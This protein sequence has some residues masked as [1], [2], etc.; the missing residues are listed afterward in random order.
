MCTVLQ[1]KEKLKQPAEKWQ[2]GGNQKTKL[3]GTRNWEMPYRRCL[4][5]SH[6]QA[7]TSGGMSLR[8]RGFTPCTALKKD[9]CFLCPCGC[10]PGD[11]QL[12]YTP[13]PFPPRMGLAAATNPFPTVSGEP[14]RPGWQ[15]GEC[16][17]ATPVRPHLPLGLTRRGRAQ[18]HPMSPHHACGRIASRFWT[19]TSAT[20]VRDG[21]GSVRAVPG[22]I[23]S[24]R[25]SNS[26]PRSAEPLQRH[27]TNRSCPI[28]T[29]LPLEMKSCVHP[30]LKANKYRR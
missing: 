24:A 27:K 30:T 5:A 11:P 28:I 19:S 18:A 20:G 8:T 25:N 16:A 17:W 9:E 10:R 15:K 4:T 6:G 29:W 23:P 7:D 13:A 22:C 1:R 21:C 12:P 3:R 2:S 26:S 14:Q